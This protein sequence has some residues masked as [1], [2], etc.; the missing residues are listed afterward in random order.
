MD[1]VDQLLFGYRNGHEL[2]AGSRSLT[3]RQQR[4]VLPHLDASFDHAD[5]QQLVGIGI[6]SLDGYLIARIWPAP[7]RPR[8]GAVWAHALLLSAEQLARVPLAGL[9]ALLRRPLDE[10]YEP[11]R[12]PLTLPDGTEHAAP[13]LLTRA[14]TWALQSGGG[15]RVIVLWDDPDEA[16]GA[17][18]ALLDASPARD[19][20]ALSFRTRERA[21]PSSPYRIQV[22]A[23]V[24]GPVGEARELVIDPRNPREELRPDRR[25]G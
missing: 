17:L 21:R 7:E 22:A 13:P 24:A 1:V 12:S 15:G 25:T 9:R 23:A 16:E 14:L 11:Y 20:I 4:D 18:I 2:I 8:P 19:R 6:P 3:P 10:R 5:A